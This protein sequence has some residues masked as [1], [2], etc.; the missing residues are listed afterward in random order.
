[1]SQEEE[2]R[3]SLFPSHDDKKIQQ[4]VIKL[5]E[6]LEEK[7]WTL[8][9]RFINELTKASGKI[10]V[11][12]GEDEIREFIISLIEEHN[13]KFLATWKSDLLLSLSQLLLDNGLQ[14]A[15]PGNKDEMA[16]ADIGITEADFAI[17]ETGTIVLIANE[18]QPRLVSLLP[19]IHVAIMKSNIIVENLDELFFLVKNSSEPTSCMTFITG[20]SRTAD[21]ELNLSLGV[22]GPKE[23]LV[24]IY[25]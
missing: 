6:E 16:K 23:L 7:K 2:D 13:A 19:P 22:H 25:P 17:A 10:M 21:I 12:K 8:I 11:A 9:N 14:F 24:L 1:M 20:P 3:K 4:K 5:R 18:R 15:S